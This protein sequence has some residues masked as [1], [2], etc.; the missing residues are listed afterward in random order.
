L[1]G[2][3]SNQIPV[4]VP[5]ANKVQSTKHQVLL[6]WRPLRLGDLAVKMV[7]SFTNLYKAQT[8]SLRLGKR[9][10]RIRERSKGKLFAGL[11]ENSKETEDE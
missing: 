10:W 7:V 5:S 3:R 11:N 8:N 4:Q 2:K 9:R 1:F 6:G